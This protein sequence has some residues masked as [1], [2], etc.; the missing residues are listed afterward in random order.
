MAVEGGLFIFFPGA[1]KCSVTPLMSMT[2][3]VIVFESS[4]FV[5]N[6]GLRLFFLQHTL[7]FF[8][9]LARFESFSSLSD[10]ELAERVLCFLFF[11]FCVDFESSS[12]SDDELLERFLYF[13]FF[14]LDFESSS[15]LSDDELLERLCFFFF[16]VRFDL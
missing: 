14:F 12:L 10:D 13:F 7:S 4:F 9:F 1:P 5:I 3:I 2:K 11:C 6:S 8:F 15:S 16:L